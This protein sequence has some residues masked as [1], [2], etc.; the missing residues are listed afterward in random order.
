MLNLKK[1]IA[2]VCVL[3][4]VLSTVAFGA[5]YTDVAEESA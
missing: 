5:T 4:M 3:A 1:V 2:S